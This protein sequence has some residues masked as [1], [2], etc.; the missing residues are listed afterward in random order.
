MAFAQLPK[1][2]RTALSDAVVHVSLLLF[3]QVQLLHQGFHLFHL[4]F[5][6]AGLP[7]VLRVSV[8]IIVVVTLDVLLGR[9]GFF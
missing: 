9:L 5:A 2:L 7:Y 6:F 3:A 1:L 8:L 4:L